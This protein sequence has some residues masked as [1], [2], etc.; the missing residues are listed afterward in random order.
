MTK[1]VLFIQG[2][3][4]NGY[5]ADAKMVASLRNEL[6]DPYHVHYPKLASNESAPD[7]GWLKQIRKEMDAIN[8]DVILAAHSFGASMLLKFLSE[9]KIKKHITGIFL[10]AT[11]FWSGDED[12]QQ[13]FKLKKDFGER[14]PENVPVFLY[15]CLDDEEVPFKHLSIYKKNLPKATVREIAG[16]GHLLNNDLAIV[17]KDIKNL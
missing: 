10:I 16:G 1:Q 5:E 11:A 6:G 3:G 9:N 4:N 7:Y 8:G 17:A 12:W 15:H 14:L 13:G 2:G